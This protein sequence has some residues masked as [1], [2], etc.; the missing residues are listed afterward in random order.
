MLG[1]VPIP[2]L[3]LVPKYLPAIGDV[4]A[5]RV[6][7]GAEAAGLGVPAL[8]PALG[9]ALGLALGLALGAGLRADFFA[10]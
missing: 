8:V 7:L 6:G 1:L 2:T 3:G 10:M 4:A 5:G 9:S